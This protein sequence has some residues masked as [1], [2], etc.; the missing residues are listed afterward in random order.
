MSPTRG[1]V[2]LATM[3][4][5]K[6]LEFRAVAVIACD[7]EIVPLQS[8][9]ETVADGEHRLGSRLPVDRSEQV[10][11]AIAMTGRVRRRSTAACASHATHA[12]GPMDE[13]WT[14]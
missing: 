13:R 8:R 5:A 11:T 10:D 12:G 14:S 4:F 7:D 2:A 1:S 3:H 6:G 9:I